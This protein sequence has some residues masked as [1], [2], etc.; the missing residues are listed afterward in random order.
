MIHQNMLIIMTSY[1]FYCLINS[2]IISGLFVIIQPY[3]VF[4]DLFQR[5]AVRTIL[6]C[7]IVFIFF[8]GIAR[9]FCWTAWLASCVQCICPTFTSELS[10]SQNT[11]ATAIFFLLGMIVTQMVVIAIPHRL[12]RM[13]FVAIII[14]SNIIASLLKIG[15]FSLLL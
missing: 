11:L 7:G 13:T 1:M 2:L 5:V 14:T 9:M 8:L 4:F 15:L 10:L 6:S 12:S 3:L